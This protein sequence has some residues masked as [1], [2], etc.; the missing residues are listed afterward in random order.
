MNGEM[1]WQRTQN[2]DIAPPIPKKLTGR[3][4]KKRT[5]E[6]NEQSS[7][8]KG[9]T[10]VSRK[11]RVM[12]CSKCKQA[13]HNK[14]KYPNTAT[15]T[16]SASTKPSK[17]KSK[18]QNKEGGDRPQ[19]KKRKHKGFGIYIEPETGETVLDPGLSSEQVL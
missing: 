2:N 19:K 15:D 12:T 4:K 16:Q 9:R 18:A 7:S 13:G 5:R 1:L 6:V 3:P 17:R 14:A 10:T 8:G 11:G